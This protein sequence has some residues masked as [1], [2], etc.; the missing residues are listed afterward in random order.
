MG[1]LTAPLGN[2]ILSLLTISS[3]GSMAGRKQYFG[4]CS[5]CG[6]LV[7]LRKL[8]PHHTFSSSWCLFR[9]VEPTWALL[10]FLVSVELVIFKW[11]PENCSAGGGGGMTR[12]PYEGGGGGWPHGEFFFVFALCICA[13][14]TQNFMENSK[15]GENYKRTF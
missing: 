11:R 12:A 10:F 15:M 7:D 1:P 9:C 8:D 4:R 6:E 14:K 3:L 13:E 2:F 5:Q